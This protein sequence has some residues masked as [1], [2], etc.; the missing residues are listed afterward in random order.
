MRDRAMPRR[1]HE[2]LPLEKRAGA[3]QKAVTAGVHVLIGAQN[4][5]FWCLIN[6]M[7]ADGSIHATIDNDPIFTHSLWRRGDAIS[8]G[9]EHVLSVADASDLHTFLLLFKRLG[10]EIEA[11]KA[12]RESR[13][14]GERC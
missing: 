11:G 13:S 14:R 1:Q 2:G 7:G 6:H 9:Q 5:R 8:F 4:E 3:L 12:W 10:C